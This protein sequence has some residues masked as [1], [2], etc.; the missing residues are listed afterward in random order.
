MS[1]LHLRFFPRLVARL[2]WLLWVGVAAADYDAAIDQFH[3]GNYHEAAEVAQVEVDRGI[4][5]SRWSQLLIECQ[6]QTGQLPAAMA[7]YEAAIRRYPTSLRLRYLGIDVL[8]QNGLT[9][10]VG[11]AEA[12]FFLQLQRS[13][14]GYLSREDTIVAGRYLTERGEDA[15]QVLQL[16]Y[17]RVRDRD[18]DFLDAYI[19]TAELAISKGD[20]A[21]AAETLEAAAQLDQ[22]DPRIDYLLSRAL[23]DSDPSMS[24]A[25]LRRA[26]SRNPRHAQ[27]LRQLAENA[28]DAERYN[29]AEALLRDVLQTNLHDAESWA[30]LA[31]ISHLRGRFGNEA[32][33]RAAALS[34]WS[35]NPRVDYRIGELLS[36]KYRFAEGAR[37]QQRALDFQPDYAP[38]QFQLSQDFLRLGDTDIGWQLAESVGE[39]DPYNVVAYNLLT[40]RD[41]MRQYTRRTRDNITVVMAGD[42]ANVFGESVLDL[43]C[44]AKRALATKYQVDLEDPIFVEIFARQDDFAIRTFGLPGGAGY[45][46]VCFGNVITAN[47]PSSQGERPSN[48]QSVLWHEFCHAVTLTKTNNRMPRWLSEGISVYEERQR[49][50]SWGEVMTPRYRQMLMGD[51]LTAISDLSGSFLRPKSSTHLMLAYYQS[52]LAVEFLIERHGFDALLNVLDDLGAGLPITDALARHTGS[53]IRLDREFVD[54]VTERAESFGPAV[55]WPSE[56]DAISVPSADDLDGLRGFVRF[57]PTNYD[58]LTRLAAAL[59]NGKQWDEAADVLARLRLLEV[60][61]GR[62]DGWL[63][64]LADVHRRR[65]DQA[66]ERS[67]L[68]QIVQLSPDPLPS[69]LRLIELDQQ[70]QDWSS[71]HRWAKNGLAINPMRSDLHRHF[72]IASQHIGNHDDAVSGWRGVLA[73]D[74]VDVAGVRYEL[75]AAYARADQNE[76]ARRSVLEALA[77]APR[78]RDAHRLL[79][80]LADD[81]LEP[82]LDPEPNAETP[83]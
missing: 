56:D 19:A 72:A 26:L 1:P 46:G 49:D 16:F 47:S 50:R 6:L 5:S 10:D 52:S 62:R 7:T 12:E 18:P 51:D 63:E 24:A 45:L 75:A 76:L 29:E 33:R 44:E 65:Q 71:V 30:L 15:R 80:T 79:L 22:A 11:K 81:P 42:E 34:T 2:G 37:S 64:K 70:D 28:I 40:L 68:G 14:R 55:Q 82:I 83:P 59:M 48:W 17:D 41:R 43:L 3:R 23:A 4:W 35:T 67:V 53:P 8:R 31:V 25:A 9:D 78:Y 39:E 20:F 61:P 60:M 21:V 77:D 66:A 36:R 38:A 74:P 54:Y 58:G 13:M 57:H 27:S 73:L 32:F 69:L